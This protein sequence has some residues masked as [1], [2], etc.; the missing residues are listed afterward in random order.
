MAKLVL[1]A[2]AVFVACAAADGKDDKASN[3][4]ATCILGTQ[5]GCSTGVCDGLSN[6]IL[7]QMK[8][9]G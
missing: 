9:N 8:K 5:R 4:T 3:A 7:A 6:Q 2:L 1:L